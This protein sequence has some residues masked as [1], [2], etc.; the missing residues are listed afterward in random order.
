MQS[1]DLL[2]SYVKPKIAIA[3]GE[4]KGMKNVSGLALKSFEGNCA[5]MPAGN[6]QK[7]GSLELTPRNVL[8]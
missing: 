1:R 5:L 3:I 8:S 6:P 4:I 7:E 2:Y